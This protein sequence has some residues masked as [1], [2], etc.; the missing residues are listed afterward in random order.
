MLQPSM[1]SSPRLKNVSNDLAPLSVIRTE[2]VLS[3]LP[4]HNLSKKGSVR[5][6]ITRKNEN[7]EVELLWNVSPNPDYGD[8]RQLAYKLDTIVINQKIDEIG[9]PLPKVIR[10]GSLRQICADLGLS[11][12]QNKTEVKKALHQNAATYIKAKLR[13]KAADGSEKTLEAGF[14][15]YSVTFTGGQLPDGTKA[16]VVYLVLDPQYRE[17]LNNAPTRPLDYEYLK[18][19]PPAAQRFYEIMSYKIF[20]AL[21]YRHMT[22]KI[23]YLEYCMYSAQQRCQDYEHVKKQMYKVHRPHLQSGYLKKV[24]CEAAVTSDGT[25]DWIFHY[26]PGPKAR[27][28]FEAFNGK[29]SKNDAA[30][31]A[32]LELPGEK[33]EAGASDETRDL[34]AFFHKRFGRSEATTPSAKDLKLA[35]AWISQ[36]GME[37]SRFIIDY[38]VAEAASTKYD[39]KMLV[40]IQQYIDD[41]VKTFTK[42]KKREA[43][44][45]LEARETQ[46]KNRYERYHQ[47]EI[48]SFKSTL[49][50]QELADLENAIRAELKAEGTLPAMINLGVRV[51]LNTTL[52]N[53]AGVLPYEEWR[54]QYL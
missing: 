36:Y 51:K 22:A 3:R 20:A 26:T 17:V 5:I 28:E 15:R 39:P 42:Q 7:G 41:A 32:E 37:Q 31:E 6:R 24:T 49:S 2:T 45:N 44:Q 46:L 29:L 40:G 13:Y 27:A 11:A 34:V 38:S 4:I 21:K 50:P 30:L 54:K 33:S 35:A 43:Q 25:Q 12:G 16:D 48:D 23:S 8:P 52:A 53:R 14:T 47:Q 19:L 1:P 10:L 9:K 18:V